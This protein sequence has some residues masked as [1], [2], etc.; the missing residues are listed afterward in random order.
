MLIMLLL[1]DAAFNLESTSQL[2]QSALILQC[3]AKMNN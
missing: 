2:S 3:Y 1:Q